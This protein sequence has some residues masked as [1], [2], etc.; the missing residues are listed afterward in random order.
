MATAERG[1]PDASADTDAAASLLATLDSTTPKRMPTG[2]A[3]AK[4][5]MTVQ[6]FCMLA[7]NIHHKHQNLCSRE[8]AQPVNDCQCSVSEVIDD[9]ANGSHLRV[10]DRAPERIGSKTLVC[11]NGNEY[12]HAVYYV[13]LSSHGHALQA[14][15]TATIRSI[16]PLQDTYQWGALCPDCT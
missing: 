2:V 5:P 10:H 6:N 11:C 15:E 12:V 16:A 3:L 13:S 7:C 9:K 14:I 1:L 8:R 4:N